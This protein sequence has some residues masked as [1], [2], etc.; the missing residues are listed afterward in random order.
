[1]DRPTHILQVLSLFPG[2]RC[3]LVLHPS[4][5]RSQAVTQCR[6]RSGTGSEMRIAFICHQGRA[7]SRLC[8][9]S[10][11]ATT[12]ILA[13][14]GYSTHVNTRHST[15]GY[16]GKILLCKRDSVRYG[17]GAKRETDFLQ[18]AERLR[19]ASSAKS[20]IGRRGSCFM[21]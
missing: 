13:T 7:P 14:R 10:P 5:Y 11:I 21:S 20:L 4:A 12:S 3:W 8:Q 6:V 9:R 2:S 17:H 15:E 19:S 1:M 18:W 16:S